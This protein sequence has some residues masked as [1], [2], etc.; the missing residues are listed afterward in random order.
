MKLQVEYVRPDALVPFAGNPRLM[1]DAALEKLRISIEAF[2]FTNPILVQK[3]TNMI[4]AG[5]QRLKAALAAGLS[6]VPVIFLNF[7]DATAKA[8][9]IADNK[10]AELAEWDF[11]PLA[12]LLLKLDHVNFDLALTGFEHEEI[13]R[14]MNWAPDEAEIVVEEVDVPEAP[15]EPTTKPGDIWLLGRHRLMCGDSTSADDI[16]KLMAGAVADSVITDP[17]YGVDY[18]S[19]N[20]DL[21]RQDGGRRIE[22][23][24]EGDAIDDY[25]RFYAGFLRLCPVAEYNTAYIFMSNKELHT[26]RLALDDAG[27]TWGDYLVWLKNNHVLG[28]K[29]YAAK[30]EFIVYCWKGKHRFYGDFSTIVLH[31]DRPQKADL[32]PTMKPVPLI[33]KLMRDG[34]PQN[35]TVLDP[36]GGSGSTLMAAEQLGRTCYMME[37]DPAYCDVIVQR[38]QRLTGGEAVREVG[39]EAV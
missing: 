17:P 23:P 20:E 16:E 7:D 3:G 8:Y 6:E 10:L 36:F 25:R 18:G 12:D 32:H 4:I 28:R 30:H 33:A 26:L 38:W 1:S 27:F 11:A 31:Y 24:I 14:L 9:N 35:G 19:K 34:T 37:L 5:H 2:G 22:K 13:E 29:D 39:R 15:A 21:N